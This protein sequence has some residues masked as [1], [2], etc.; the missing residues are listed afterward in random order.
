MVSFA[1]VVR[2]LNEEGCGAEVVGFSAALA[3]ERLWSVGLWVCGTLGTPRF[4]ASHLLVRFIP[5]QSW[6]VA[7]Y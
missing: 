7:Y 5:T 1:V 6:Q 3:T 2:A 4:F